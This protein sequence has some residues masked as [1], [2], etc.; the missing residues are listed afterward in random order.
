MAQVSHPLVGVGVAAGSE[1]QPEEANL[2]AGARV[3]GKFKR[4]AGRAQTQRGRGGGSLTGRPGEAWNIHLEG[5]EARERF[6]GP[7]RMESREAH[8]G[9]RDGLGLNVQADERI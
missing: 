1:R 6:L 4:E 9:R 5:T 3:P 2:E 8:R 7:E